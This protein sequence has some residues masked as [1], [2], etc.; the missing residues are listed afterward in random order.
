MGMV[1]GREEGGRGPVVFGWGWGGGEGFS[2]HVLCETAESGKVSRPC[3]KEKRRG[4]NSCFQGE[5]PT[6]T[7]FSF[8]FFF[9]FLS[10]VVLV[11]GGLFRQDEKLS[12]RLCW[13]GR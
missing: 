11:G 9:F 10:G 2:E 13:R 3:E 12:S 4:S 7:S 1:V 8:R 6:T 5:P